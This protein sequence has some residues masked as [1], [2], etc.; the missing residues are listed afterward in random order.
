ML[1]PKQVD[2]AAKIHELTGGRGADVA[3]ECTSVQQAMDTLVD[4]L[5]PRGVLVVVS[6]WGIAAASTCS[7]W[8]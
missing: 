7:S 8:C 6:I 2:V 3:F 1:D 5:A 4:A